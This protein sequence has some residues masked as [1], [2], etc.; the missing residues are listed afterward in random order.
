MNAT[1]AEV[2]RMSN[3][4]PTTIFHRVTKDTD[5]LGYEMKE[6][7]NIVGNLTSVHM[8]ED[9]W[10]DPRVFRPERFIDEK[11]QFQTDPWLIPFGLG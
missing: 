5:F 11:G 7:Y 8:D 1:L 2:S 6:N 3:I 4:G 10:K 9:H